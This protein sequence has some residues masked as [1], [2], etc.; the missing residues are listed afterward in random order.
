MKIEWGKK[1]SCPA[2][3]L[4]FYDMGKSSLV[5]PYCQYSFE[6]DSL[7]SKGNEAPA[8]EIEIEEGTMEMPGFE[9]EN[10][11]VPDDIQ[12]ND[13]DEDLDKFKL[14]DMQ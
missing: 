11:V 4:T 1:I 10:E 13:L 9:F 3:A 7:T 2:C 8:D 6:A 12:D 5:C 14:S